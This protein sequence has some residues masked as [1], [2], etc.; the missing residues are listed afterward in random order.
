MRQEQNPLLVGHP[1]YLEDAGV[2]VV[3]PALAALLAQPP[4]H[5]FSDEGPALGTVLLDQSPH[6]IVLL[7]APRLLPQKLGFIIVRLEVGIVVVVLGQLLFVDFLDH[8]NLT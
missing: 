7:L 4:L 8:S 3:V 2:E 5:E 6:Q 1:F